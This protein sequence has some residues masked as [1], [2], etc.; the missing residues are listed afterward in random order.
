[1]NEPTASEDVRRWR[2]SLRNELNVITMATA[3]AAGLIDH[4]ESLE[5][6]RQHLARAEAACRRCHDLLVDWPDGA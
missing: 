5:R 1:M 3:T 2:H 6:V 4:G